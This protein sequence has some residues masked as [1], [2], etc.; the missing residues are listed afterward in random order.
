LNAKLLAG[1]L[2]WLLW[3]HITCSSPLLLLYS[4]AK[5]ST[6]FQLSTLFELSTLSG[7]S[8]CY[9][10]PLLST[11]LLLFSYYSTLLYLTSG[12]YTSLL[13]LLLSFVVVGGASGKIGQPFG[14]DLKRPKDLAQG[15]AGACC[16]C[17]LPLW[18]CLV[19]TV[20]ALSLS[21]AAGAIWCLLCFLYTPTTTLYY[22][23]TT[24]GAG[25][26]CYTEF[27]HTHTS[28]IPLC[29]LLRCAATPTAT[30]YYY[31]TT[32]PPST[33]TL[34]YSTTMYYSPP[35]LLPNYC[36]PSSY[37]LLLPNYRCPSYLLLLLLYSTTTTL[38]Y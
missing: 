28:S 2:P 10:Y 9:Y 35:P 33:T 13:L 14:V 16:A 18:C 5:L 26:L 8:Y 17:S 11:V 1:L 25:S 23:S 22:L 4:V 6:L 21:G 27:W 19:L 7:C 12:C 36:Y 3:W 31:S 38:L 37:V 30:L 29:C 24:A 32:P 34:Y 15:K 20:P